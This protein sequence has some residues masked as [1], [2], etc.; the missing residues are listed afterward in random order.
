MLEFLFSLVWLSFGN[1]KHSNHLKFSVANAGYQIYFYEHLVWR[2]KLWV[3]QLY[4]V[5]ALL[6]GQ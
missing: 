5:P 2:L 3:D 6:E 4:H 1:L